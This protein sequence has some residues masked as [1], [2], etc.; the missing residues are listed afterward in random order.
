MSNPDFLRPEPIPGRY[1]SG[2]S[3][4][5]VLGYTVFADPPRI[6]INRRL[7]QLATVSKAPLGIRGRWRATLAHEAAHILLH[8]RL[9]RPGE[10]STVQI[11]E[12]EL[13]LQAQ[14]RANQK[15][16]REVQ[17]NMGMAALLMPRQ[18]VLDFASA[19]LSEAVAFPPL[20]EGSRDGAQLVQET[21]KAFTVSR[22]A[23]HLRL[24]NF[25]FMTAPE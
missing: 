18:P 1:H 11:D 13:T 9:F 16:W 17:A 24:A 21:A 19:V 20:T 7:T 23:A 6:V 4:T 22:R 3:D 2:S 10:T 5:N 14:G 15:D 25:G 12:T 8:G